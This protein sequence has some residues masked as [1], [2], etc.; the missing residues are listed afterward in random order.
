MLTLQIGSTLQGGKYEIIQI[1]GRG[2][3][4]VTY[5][6]RHVLLNET[7]A[8]KEFFPEDYCTRDEHTSRIRLTSLTHE[9][10]VE[11]LRLRFLSEARNIR[12]LNHPGIVKIYD[13]FEENDTAYFVMDFIDGYS[14]E[15]LIKSGGALREDIAVRYIQQACS[16]IDHIH[17]RNMTHFDIKPA[18]LMVRRNDGAL[19]LIDFGLSKQ[20]NENGHVHSTLL[21]GISRGFSPPEQYLQE[22]IS[23]FSPQTDVYALGATLYY[24]I[25]GEYP[26]ESISFQIRPLELP[27]TVSPRLASVVLKAM[28]P[29]RDDRTQS[30]RE[31]GE[32]LAEAVRPE[33]KPAFEP[34]SRATE[35]LTNTSPSEGLAEVDVHPIQPPIPP[36]T[37]HKSASPAYTDSQPEYNEE[38]ERKKDRKKKIFIIAG[39]ILAAF[40]LLIWLVVAF[41]DDP[42]ASSDAG[43]EQAYEAPLEET[44]DMQ[45]ESPLGPGLY[46]GQITVLPNVGEVPHGKGVLKISSGKFVGCVYDGQFDKGKLEG[47][48]VYT[49]VDGDVFQGKFKENLYDS[50]RYT[51][52]STGEYF[53]GTFRDGQPADG[54]W[55]SKSGKL[56]E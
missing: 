24:L 52:K 6:A 38:E 47:E 25:V 32:Q 56:L 40:V 30:A 16:A 18:N 53:E 23:D 49:T 15:D 2:G 48:T 4:G 19:I 55:Y 46:T 54:H 5:L 11:K 9:E 37:K 13:I 36:V 26:P 3:F 43:I 28:N 1:L 34:K 33:A 41:G 17:S 31:L 27:A 51:V 45:W 7:F 29:K 14:L 35:V 42:E 8:I 21:V 44:V 39:T 10:L 22:G 12:K 20:Y 50:G